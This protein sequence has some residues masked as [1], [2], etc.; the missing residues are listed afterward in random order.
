MQEAALSTVQSG[1]ES[2]L[3]VGT[4]KED[5]MQRA[6][7]NLGPPLNRAGIWTEDPGSSSDHKLLTSL[8]DRAPAPEAWGR[9]GGPPAPGTT[10]PHTAQ[11]AVGHG[12][13]GIAGRPGP[14]PPLRPT[15]LGH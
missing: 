11:P 14:G 13:E 9:P 2:F 3:R 10:D 1:A 7:G 5:I 8:W 6:A 4:V 12:P 15:A